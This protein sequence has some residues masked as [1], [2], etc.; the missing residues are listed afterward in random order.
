[1]E[2]VSA[3]QEAPGEFLLKFKTVINGVWHDSPSS[4]ELHI[5]QCRYVT[6]TTTTT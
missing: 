5:Q 3:S 1:M 2:S 6:I 4:V